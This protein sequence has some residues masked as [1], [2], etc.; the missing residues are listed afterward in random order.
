MFGHSPKMSRTIAY[1]GISP[2]GFL[3]AVREGNFEI[4]HNYIQQNSDVLGCL[5]VRDNKGQTAASIA[6]EIGLMKI[7]NLLIDNRANVNIPDKNDETPIYKAVQ[8]GRHE[9][10]H[11]LAAADGIDLEVEGKE[12]W[13]HA[14]GKT[15]LRLALEKGNAEIVEVL[16]SHGAKFVD[17]EELL[18]VAKQFNHQGVIEYLNENKVALMEMTR[19]K[20]E[21]EYSASDSDEESSDVDC[22]FYRRY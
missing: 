5:D 22:N 13:Y 3:K 7:L 16:I 9:V 17:F 11:A 18:K 14:K 12:E 2:A 1:E 20:I 6:A 19:R 4:V 10:V 21:E 8:S 15:P